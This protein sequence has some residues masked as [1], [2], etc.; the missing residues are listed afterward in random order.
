MKLPIMKYRDG[1]GRSVQ[2]KFGGYDH[3]DSAGDGDIYDMKNMS[4]RRFPMLSPRPIR[5]KIK[6]IALQTPNGLFAVG[7]DLYYTDGTTLYY[8]REN[9]AAVSVINVVNG[10]KTFCCIND[11]LIILPD[12]KYVRLSDHTDTGTLYRSVSGSMT[13]QDGTY[14][15]V[16]A[17]SN[18]IYSATIDFSSYFKAGDGVKISNC[19]N[20][21]NNQT[22]IIR[23]ISGHYMRFYENS[24]KNCAESSATISREMPDMD[25]ICCSDNRLWGAKGNTI[26]ASKLGDPFN[27]NVFDGIST[28]SYSVNLLTAGSIT[29]CIAYLGYPIFFKENMIIRVMGNKPSNFQTSDDTAFGVREG[30]SGSLALAGGVLFY[31]SPHGIC[32]YNGGAPRVVSENSGT[33]LMF[34]AQG[35]SDGKR[36][37]VTYRS[38]YSNWAQVYSGSVHAST[39]FQVINSELSLTDGVSYRLETEN[40][41]FYSSPYSN[42]ITF[43]N[44]FIRDCGSYFKINTLSGSYYGSIKLYRSE[45]AE[46]FQETATFVYDTEKGLWEKEDSLPHVCYCAGTLKHSPVLYALGED[47]FIRL[48]GELNLTS[49]ALDLVEDSE[50]A[51]ESCVEFGDFQGLLSASVTDPNSKTVHKLH[52]R[53]SM[54]SGSS[55]TLYIKYDCGEWIPVRTMTTDTKRSFYLPVIPHRCDHYRLKFT[56]TG[57]YTIHSLSKESASGSAQ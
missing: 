15:G 16:S 43:G 55:V 30:C 34:E 21:V 50:G 48:M 49:N 13:F 5:K 44:I 7:E 45:G 54:E 46:G 18:T 1:I 37:F 35:G 2:V 4:S 57:D 36:Y 9:S 40:G 23:E 20:T 56:G 11:Y 32:A 24:F 42:T 31:V 52:V 25:F 17:S 41:V 22:L 12:K 51:V 27:W 14:E 53:L 28:D 8:V 3:T 6:N 19:A 38:N 29:G 26:Y 33:E 47:G 10:R 39:N